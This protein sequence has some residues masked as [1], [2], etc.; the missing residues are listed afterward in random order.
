MTNAKHAE[1][2]GTDD[3]LWDANDAARYLKVSRSWVYQRAEAGLLPCSARRRL[4]SLR[5]RERPG[6][7]PRRDAGAEGPALS[8]FS[9]GKEGLTVR[10][11]ERCC[12]S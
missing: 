12:S 5:S 10:G 6:F 7:R 2:G 1:S 8:R 4:A 9:V 11:P 3:E